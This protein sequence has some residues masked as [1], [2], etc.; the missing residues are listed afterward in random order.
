MESFLTVSKTLVLVAFF[1]VYCG[2]L[3]Y[4][5]RGRNRKKI[6]EHRNIPFLED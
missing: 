6:E 1:L 2:V 4:L 3:A 5:Y